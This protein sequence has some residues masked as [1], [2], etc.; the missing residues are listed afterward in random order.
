MKY[1][2]YYTDEI[3][4]YATDYLNNRY[5][6]SDSVT[7]RRSYIPII[8]HIMSNYKISYMKIDANWPKFYLSD[9]MPMVITRLREWLQKSGIKQLN[10]HTKILIEMIADRELGD[11]IYDTY[12]KHL[13]VKD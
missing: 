1:A 9:L 2:D 3:I 12:L 10:E 13:S 11:V 8:A 5:G 7:N 4:K 6:S